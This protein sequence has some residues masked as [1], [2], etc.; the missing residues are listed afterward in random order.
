M[1]RK[2]Q[3]ILDLD[4]VGDR[5]AA[6]AGSTYYDIYSLR[7]ILSP[8]E[9]LKHI[10]RYSES[11]VLVYINDSFRRPLFVSVLLRLMSR[12]RC[13]SLDCNGHR[14]NITFFNIIG[15]ASKFAID[16]LRS[17]KVV[18][19]AENDEREIKYKYASIANKQLRIDMSASPVYMRT[20]LK[21]G[22]TAGGSVGHIAGVLNN[23]DC[24]CAT[25][26]FITS[27][28]IPT[29]RDDI[30]KHIVDAGPDFR[31][32]TEVQF[33]HYSAIFFNRS[34]E[35]L[36][37][38]KPSFIYQRYSLGNMSGIMLARHFGVPLA[39]EFNGSE[40]WVSRNWGKPVKYGD[41]LERI[42]STVN[43]AADVV[44]VVSRPLKEQLVAAGVE[45]GK[46]LV[47]PNGVDPAKYSPGIDGSKIRNKYRLEGK[48]VIGF[49]GT[50]GMWHGAEVLAE[51]FGKLLAKRPELRH[52]TS[53][54]MIGD[55]V[56]MKQV[57]E[58]LNKYD[59]MK[60]A[61]L[62]GIVPQSEGPEHLAAADIL[63][64]PHVPNPDGSPFFGSPTKLFEYMAMGKGIVASDLAQIGEILDDNH[65][66]VLVEPGNSD[67]FMHGLEVLLDDKNKRE[68]LGHE[69][70][71]VVVE[72]YTWKEHTRRIIEKLKERCGA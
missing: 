31:D 68:S 63:A 47:N 22:L 10:F 17:K 46:I 44:V 7:E 4:D 56:M 41:L 39:L 45:A 50:F 34:L 15:F 43:L 3:F 5:A 55:G 23:L 19:N 37:G 12:G 32:F 64:S 24:F 33:L 71:R 59:V 72:K 53:L 48:T 8:R 62:T 54:L 38:A 6:P 20:D 61:T 29:V 28:N 69:A 67:D 60:Y 11:T 13:F 49:I 51:A 21:L 57:R 1:N 42:E 18:R 14:K 40:V 27:D 25:P 30:E 66:A 70:R 9:L 58:N 52:K 35:I 2:K 26:I 36:S 65:T 16:Y